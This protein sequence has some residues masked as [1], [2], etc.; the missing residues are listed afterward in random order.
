MAQ[1]PINEILLVTAILGGLPREFQTIVIILEAEDAT[2]TVNSIQLKLCAIE[3]TIRDASARNSSPDAMA[4]F[5]GRRSSVCG[6]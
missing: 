3:Q 1:E 5:A 4:I 6:Y 2:L